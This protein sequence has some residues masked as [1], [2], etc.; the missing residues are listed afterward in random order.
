LFS[1]ISPDKSSISLINF[2]NSKFLSVTTN[3]LFKLK[4]ILYQ[5]KYLTTD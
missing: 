1:A 3:H 4:V 2:S 5:I